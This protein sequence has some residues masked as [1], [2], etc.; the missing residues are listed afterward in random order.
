MN[1]TKLAKTLTKITQQPD[2]ETFI[3]DLL[4]AYK[5]PKATITLLQQGDRNTAT[6][7]GQVGLKRKLWFR[8]LKVEEDPWTVLKEIKSSLRHKERFIILTDYEV[9]LAWDTVTEEALDID[10]EDLPQ[11]YDFFFP[12]AGIEKTQHRDENP[13]DVKAASR[14][15]RLYDLIKKDNP[16]D[17]EH[18]TH[19]LNVFL[20]RLLFCYFAEDTGIFP[21]DNLFTNGI[22]SQTERDG[23]NLSGYFTELFNVLDCPA[24]E[25]RHFRD[26]FLAFPYVNGGL[27][28]HSISV[29]NFTARSRR[30]IVAAGSLDWAAINPDIFGSMI[31]AVVTPEHRGGLGM[32]YTSVPNIMKVIEP[33]FLDELR[34]EYD[35][36]RDSRTKLERLQERLARIKIF[37]P[38]CGSGNFLIIAYKELRELEMRIIKRIHELSKGVDAGAELFGVG[39]GSRSVI[40]L[41]Q[42]YGIEL[43][44]FAH[45]IAIL[46]LWLA[47]HQMNL[48]FGEVFGRA[49]PTLPLNEQGHIVHGNACRL[50]WEE[51]CPKEEGW[52]VFILGNP[53]Y[54]GSSMQDADQKQDMKSVFQGFKNYKNLDYIAI[55]FKKA[56]DYLDGS[57]SCAAFVS[58]NS[59]CQGEQVG[60]L[61]P[62]VQA[63]ISFHLPHII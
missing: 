6:E 48:R 32:H 38:A 52:E 34:A 7:A 60:L 15:A 63:E 42:F 27:F 23:S 41:S 11:H 24:K 51:V 46:A 1:E 29:P 55:W 18:F 12:W 50:D 30:A 26:H 16:R 4:R 49:Q 57:N 21:G 61:W 33:L 9:L 2:P 59:I 3:Y 40:R 20:S 17:D 54:L 25:R 56:A 39:A 62:Y 58:T 8:E 19:E 22:G 5:L 44:D 47:E 10:L 13:A 31:Q 14:M 36:A 35:K 45:E 43:D 37:D 53:P 28:R